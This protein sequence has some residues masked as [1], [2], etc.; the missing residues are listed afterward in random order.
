[1]SWWGVATQVLL[2]IILVVVAYRCGNRMERNSGIS[3]NTGRTAAERELRWERIRVALD[4]SLSSYP[5]VQMMGLQSLNELIR[6]GAAIVEDRIL[7]RAVAELVLDRPADALPAVG[8]AEQ[9]SA[10]TTLLTTLDQ[11]AA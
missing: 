2:G 6:S 1:M 4:D 3:A 11:V 7:A 10:A 9:H 8:S 5:P